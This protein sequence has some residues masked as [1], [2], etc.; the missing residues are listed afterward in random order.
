MPGGRRPPADKTILIN[1]PKF[2]TKSKPAVSPQVAKMAKPKAATSPSTAAAVPK[3]PLKPVAKSSATS[4]PANS[5]P[6]VAEIAKSSSPTVASKKRKTAE[7][8]GDGKSATRVPKL[9]QVRQGL[10]VIFFQQGRV[11]G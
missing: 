1:I 6:P 2:R 11:L 8:N 7:K 9:P 3:M 5:S 4:K 10:M